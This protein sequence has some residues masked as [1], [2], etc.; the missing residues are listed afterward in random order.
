[1][2][3]MGP[4]Q[5]KKGS[6]TLNSKPWFMQ[7][8]PML[9]ILATVYAMLLF[10]M[11][12]RDGQKGPHVG[13]HAVL[14]KLTLIM[15]CPGPGLRLIAVASREALLIVLHILILHLGGQVVAAQAMQE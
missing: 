8:N 5:P 1:M 14:N 12:P 13:L 10:G 4:F 6:D 3:L 15:C 2:F 9:H 7:E 11:H